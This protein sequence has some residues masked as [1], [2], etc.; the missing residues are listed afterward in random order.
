MGNKKTV[1]TV[2]ALVIVAA[3]GSLCVTV[4]GLPPRVEVRPHEAL[5]EVMAQ[6]AIKQLGP[7]GR[8]FLMQRDTVLYPNPAAA[9]QVRAFHRALRRAGV[10]AAGTNVAKID[11]LRMVSAPPADFFQLLKKASEADVVVSFL[12]PPVLNAD[13][14]AKLGGKAPKVVAVCSGAMP[15]QLNLKQ[16]FESKLLHVAVLSRTDVSGNLPDSGHAQA[17]FNHY[18]TLATSAEMVPSTPIPERK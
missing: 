18:F 16:A 9:A 7:G 13:Q 17:W 2:A 15:K 11:P 6:E 3:A 1:G 14:L 10:S 4:V 5:G 8:I 12:G